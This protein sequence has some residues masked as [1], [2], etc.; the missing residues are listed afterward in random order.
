MDVGLHC[1]SAINTSSVFIK[2]NTTL[3]LVLLIA[4]YRLTQSQDN[5]LLQ[6]INEMLPKLYV[7]ISAAQAIGAK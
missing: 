3:M 6:V 7:L 2:L 5:L 1:Q 4:V